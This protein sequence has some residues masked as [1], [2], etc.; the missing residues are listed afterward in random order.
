MTGTASS[1]WKPLVLSHPLNSNNAT[2]PCWAKD[3]R[4]PVLIQ[5]ATRQPRGGLLDERLKKW[6]R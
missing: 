4:T 6:H 1:C 3:L 2:A 5:I